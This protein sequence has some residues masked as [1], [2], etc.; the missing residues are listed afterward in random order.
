MTDHPRFE[1]IRSVP[2]L[3]H[4]DYNG[5]RLVDSVLR[6]ADWWRAMRR[7]PRAWGLHDPADAE[8]TVRRPVTAEVVYDAE[9]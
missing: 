6:L 5:G 8:G 7:P 4:L 9:D 1:P 2:D 3:A